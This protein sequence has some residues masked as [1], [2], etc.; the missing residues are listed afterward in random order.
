MNLYPILI[1]WSDEDES[2]IS[3]APDLDGCSAFGDTP[4][5]ALRE[6]QTAMQLWLDVAREYNDPIPAPSRHPT[7]AKAS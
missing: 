1:F 6:L 7:L 5:E 4:E 3:V 2:Y